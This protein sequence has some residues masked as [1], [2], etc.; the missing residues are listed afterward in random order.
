MEQKL[1]KDGTPD[2]RTGNKGISGKVGPKKKP[3][4]EKKVDVG[5]YVR[6]ADVD[7]LGKAKIREIALN[8]IV[9][10]LSNQ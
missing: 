4:S 5:I 6:K 7:L 3:E 1:K 9:T 8:A 2:L 10:E